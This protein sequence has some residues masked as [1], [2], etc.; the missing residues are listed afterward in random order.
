MALLIVIMP[1][2]FKSSNWQQLVFLG[3]KLK[4][5]LQTQKARTA[6]KR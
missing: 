2:L 6:A 3:N 4:V 1:P 5:S